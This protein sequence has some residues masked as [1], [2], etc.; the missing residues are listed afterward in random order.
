MGMRRRLATLALTLVAACAL[1]AAAAAEVVQSGTVRVT[2]HADFTPH[3]LPRNQAAPITVAVEGKISAT[4]GSQP[5]P[6]SKLLIELNGAGKIDPVGL[7]TCNASSLQTTS[8]EE[9]L[10]RCRPARVGSGSFEAELTF[11]GKPIVVDGRSL[12]FNGLV[13]GRPGMLIHIY[14]ERPVRLTL[15]IPIK[16][17]P[18]E[19]KFGTVLT[20]NVP[21]LAGGFGSITELSLRIGR[22]FTYKGARHSYLSA[23][24]AAPPG[25]T[26][27][28]F[29][30]ARG[31]FTFDGGR[32]LH[33]TLT[34]TCQVRNPGRS[35]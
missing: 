13:G 25:F 28:P 31:F 14:I 15:V 30:F 34:R 29:T 17:S 20:T 16:I 3:D 26:G 2:F 7:P 18:G 6:L 12:V 22:K 10:E 4:D 19:G 11:N 35:G 8:S 5:P 1:T 23:A 33:T 27:G 24:C 32:T 21:K 9:A